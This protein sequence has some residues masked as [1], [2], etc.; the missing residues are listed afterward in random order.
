VI[1]IHPGREKINFYG[2]LNLH[3]DREIAIRSDVMNGVATTQHFAKILEA[4]P[5]VFITLLWNR[6]SWHQGQQIQDVLDANP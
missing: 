6:A 2:T 4:L 1:R 3:T 5:G